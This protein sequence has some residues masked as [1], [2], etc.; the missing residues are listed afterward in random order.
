MAASPVKSRNR[1]TMSTRQ[2]GNQNITTSVATPREC[3]V[4]SETT[5]TGTHHIRKIS[6][7]PVQ[8]QQK[9]LSGEGTDNSSTHARRNSTNNPCDTGG[10]H[11]NNR[12][13]GDEC[14]G[15]K[16]STGEGNTTADT[17]DRTTPEPWH[18]HD[19][20]LSNFRTQCC[21]S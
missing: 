14:Q 7:T 21:S 15:E 8:R 11:N 12:N 6:A 13:I 2:R 16:H 1:T 17:S 18:C 3:K 5:D 9:A 20:L 19:C 4:G 10:R